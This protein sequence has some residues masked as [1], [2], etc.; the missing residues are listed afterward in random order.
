MKAVLPVM[1]FVIGIGAGFVS[2]Q[3]KGQ[4]DTLKAQIEG[5]APGVSPTY[6]A[7]VSDDVLARSRAKM[8]KR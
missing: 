7:E 1:C 4:V 6:V 2:G 3:W 8:E 5:Q